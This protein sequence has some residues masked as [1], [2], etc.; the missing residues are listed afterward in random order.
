[1]SLLKTGLSTE[2]YY[3]TFNKVYL[4][5]F[6]EYYMLHYPFFKEEEDDFLQCQKNMTDYCVKKVENLEGKKVLEIGC[7]NGIQAIYIMRKYKPAEIV[8]IDLNY[9]NIRI[10]K[11]ELLKHGIKNIKFLIGDA[12]K[13]AEIDDDSI[14]IVLNIESAFHYPEKDKFIKQIYRVLK[15]G[16]EF[17]IADIIQKQEGK[18]KNGFWKRRMH[19]HHISESDYRKLIEEA[20][21]KLKLVEDVTDHVIES[22][23]RCIEWFKRSKIIE[24]VFTRIWATIMLRLNAHLLKKKQSYFIFTG[25]KPVV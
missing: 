13:L 15:P 24:S 19:F 23:Y 17:V 25:T 16:G 21:L 11:E 14:D 2:N 3:R 18:R 22:F 4:N 7:G 6:G 5:T 12:Q 20:N 10:A 1:M 9:D 8:G